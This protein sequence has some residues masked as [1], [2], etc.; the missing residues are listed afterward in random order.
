MR[1]SNTIA[2]CSKKRAGLL[3]LKTGQVEFTFEGSQILQYRATFKEIDLYF[4]EQQKPVVVFKNDVVF[5]LPYDTI[6]ME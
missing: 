2:F 1:D 4:P 3:H 5:T 6:G